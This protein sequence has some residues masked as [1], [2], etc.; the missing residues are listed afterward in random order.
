MRTEYANVQIQGFLV[1]WEGLEAQSRPVLWPAV[2]EAML[3]SS[4]DNN[5]GVHHLMQ[6]KQVS[7]RYLRQVRVTEAA[8]TR[9][10]VWRAGVI[11]TFHAQ[12][13]AQLTLALSQMWIP[14][15]PG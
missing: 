10:H 13:N 7:D 11:Q 2:M 9:G 5:V 12:L 4:T 8:C 15:P 14:S 6:K 3:R 1:P